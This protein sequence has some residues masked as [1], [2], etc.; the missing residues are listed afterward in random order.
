MHQ[1]LVGTTRFDISVQVNF[2]VLPV[3]AESYAGDY[4]HVSINPA[5]GVTIWKWLLGV[6]VA[7]LRGIL[8]KLLE[9]FGVLPGVGN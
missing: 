7:R 8:G 6:L 9:H 1:E 4:A 2:G 3:Q 5:T